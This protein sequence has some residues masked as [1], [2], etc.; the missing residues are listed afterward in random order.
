[1][2]KVLLIDQQPVTARGITQL[3]EGSDCI[4]IYLPLIKDVAITELIS[5]HVPDLLII[6]IVNNQI[7]IE[8][9]SLPII[10]FTNIDTGDG[11]A[12]LFKNG[13]DNHISKHAPLEEIITGVNTVLHQQRFLCSY[14]RSLMKDDAHTVKFNIPTLSG[15]ERQIILLIAEGKSDKDI[16]DSL[17]L[18]Y[19]TV[20]THRKNISRKVGF[21][22]KNAGDLITLVKMLNEA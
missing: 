11:L 3:L 17:Y 14:S 6:D 13:I 4:V 9:I 2:T 16:A 21:S 18:S 5:N 22:L 7:E 10:G 19:H 20:R 15:R 12:I 8:Y 1:M